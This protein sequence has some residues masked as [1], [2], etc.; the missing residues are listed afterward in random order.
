MRGPPVTAIDPAPTIERD[1]K[2][3]RR[4]KSVQVALSLCAIV[5]VGQ[6]VRVQVIDRHVYMEEMVQGLPGLRQVPSQ[7]GAILDRNG[8]YLALNNYDFRI[9]AA[10]NQ[11]PDTDTARV[12]AKLADVLNLPRTELEAKL[13]GDR[14]WVQI[15]PQVSRDVGKAVGALKL[16]GIDAIPMVIRVYPESSLAARVLGFVA[17]DG[18]GYYGVEGFYD[19]V[20]RGEAGLRDDRWNPWSQPV[21]FTD[22]RARSWK[23]P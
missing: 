22:R 10:P 3:V 5:I 20:L 15:S 12:A 11:I 6:L 9:E 2:P 18:K 4:I 16:P 21:S 23:L 13:D 17:A 19:S 14:K 7:R 1:I 8:A